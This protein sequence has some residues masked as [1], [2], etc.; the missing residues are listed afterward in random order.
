MYG[1]GEGEGTWCKSSSFLGNPQIPSS[2]EKNIASHTN[3][4]S[5]HINTIIIELRKT[6]VS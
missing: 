4:N 2:E 1:G 3:A 5:F 6:F